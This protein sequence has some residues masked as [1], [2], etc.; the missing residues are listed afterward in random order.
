VRALPLPQGLMHTKK[1]KPGSTLHQKDTTAVRF[2]KLATGLLLVFTLASAACTQTAA[3]P[4]PTSPPAPTQV[5][6]ASPTSPPAPTQVP[7]VAPTKPTPTQLPTASPTS[8]PAPTQL[9]TASP[10][11]AAV[12]SEF[13]LSCHG[14]FEKVFKASTD[15][16]FY[17]GSKVNPHTTVELTAEKP[18]ASGKGVV[19]C[20]KC[21][22]PHPLPLTSVKDVPSADLIYCFGCH[23]QGVFTP[24]SKCHEGPI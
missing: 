19:A 14:P 22:Q 13:C 17:D 15:Y 6:T 3:T 11:T 7:T 9:P 10:T 18:H 23:H 4:T 5:P 8:P 16:T 21:H 2:R 24:C 20:A 1:D 12:T